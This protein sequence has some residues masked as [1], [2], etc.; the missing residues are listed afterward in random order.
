MNGF[1]LVAPSRPDCLERLGHRPPKENAFIELR[2]IIAQNPLME[3]PVDRVQS[4]LNDYGLTEAEAHAECLKIYT[5]VFNHHSSRLAL[6]PGVRAGLV[7][8]RQFLWLRDEEADAVELVAARHQYEHLLRTALEATP[9][10]TVRAELDPLA[11][12]LGVSAEGCQA[13]YA[14][15]ARRIVQTAFEQ[16]LAT[17]PVWQLY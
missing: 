4:I 16:A 15:E 8:L 13:S 6:P 10:S 12:A 17:G 5:A 14:A 2:N 1:E 7:R 11:E 9:S 3:L